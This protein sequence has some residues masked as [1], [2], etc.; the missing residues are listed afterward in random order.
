MPLG[1]LKSRNIKFTPELPSWKQKAIQ[2]LHFGNVCK[3]LICLKNK[4]ISQK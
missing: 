4:S 1:V 3:V 2:K